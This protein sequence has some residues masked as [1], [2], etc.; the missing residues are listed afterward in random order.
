MQEMGK[1]HRAV[2]WCLVLIYCLQFPTDSSIGKCSLESRAAQSK[3]REVRQALGPQTPKA[4]Q[5]LWSLHSSI[6]PR[7]R[8]AKSNDW[9]IVFQ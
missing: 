5:Q 8:P 1:G 4:T 9:S 6:G 2:L 7:V 3:L